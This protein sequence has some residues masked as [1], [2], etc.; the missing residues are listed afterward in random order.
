M[1]EVT[2]AAGNTPTTGDAQPAAGAAAPATA[3]V[4]AVAS[5]PAAP[6]TT[7]Q[8]ASDGQTAQGAASTEGD[9]ARAAAKPLVPEKYEFKAPDGVSLDDAIVAEYSAVAKELGLPQDAAQKVIDKLAP[10][11]AQQ[12]VNAIRSAM[13]SASEAWVAASKTDKEFGGEKLQESLSFAAKALDRFG[14]PELR[15]LLGAYH[16]QKNP[17]GT[18]LGNHPEIIRAFIRAGKAISED[19]FVA[20]ATAPSRGETRNAAKALYPNQPA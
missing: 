9:Q 1:S 5:P 11:L 18:G 17:M 3:G 12:N 19:R 20:G 7:S 15:S 13:Q 2:Q 6:A 4:A 8:Q 10:K 16:P 14:T